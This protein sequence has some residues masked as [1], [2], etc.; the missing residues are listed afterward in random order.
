MAARN[1]SIGKKLGPNVTLTLNGE[2]S[3]LQNVSEGHPSECHVSQ[4]RQP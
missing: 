1:D 4:Q 3:K 2:Q